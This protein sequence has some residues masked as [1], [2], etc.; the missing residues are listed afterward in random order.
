LS[1]FWQEA[2]ERMVST[3]VYNLDR[4]QHVVGMLRQ[5]HELAG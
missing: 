1:R 2:N 3:R 5:L 4:R